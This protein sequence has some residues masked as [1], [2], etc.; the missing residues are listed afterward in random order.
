[1]VPFLCGQPRELAKSGRTRGVAAG[2]GELL[3]VRFLIHSKA[4]GEDSKQHAA[5]FIVGVVFFHSDIRRSK[6]TRIFP[7]T[8]LTVLSSN[9]VCELYNL[10]YCVRLLSSG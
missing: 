7:P 4:H 2:E 5:D 1:M 10:V 6:L 9:F 8:F 3:T